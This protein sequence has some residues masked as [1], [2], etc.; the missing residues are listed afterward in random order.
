MLIEELGGQFH[1]VSGNCG[2]EGC[3]RLGKQWR[4]GLGEQFH[5]VSGNC[6]CVGGGEWEG[7]TGE[8]KPSKSLDCNL[9]N[10]D[11]DCKVVNCFLTFSLGS[12]FKRGSTKETTSG[13]ST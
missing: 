12:S 3:R 10:N 1:P 7:G 11:I 8:W 2:F 9:D 4:L 6:G 13:F 5:P